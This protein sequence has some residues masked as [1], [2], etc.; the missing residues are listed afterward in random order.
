MVRPPR[1][2]SPVMVRMR[3]P[4]P[5][6]EDPVEAEALDW[7]VRLRDDDPPA[8]LEPQFRAWLDA[9]PAHRLA[10]V[11]A[12]QL[13]DS[14]DQ[15]APPSP[16]VRPVRPW[17][18]QGRAVAASIAATLVIGCAAVFVALDPAPDLQTATGEVRSVQLADGSTVILDAGSAIDVRI[19]PDDRTITLRKGRAWF[20]VA[21]EQ[22]RPF[23]VRSGSAAVHDIGTAFEVAHRG[24]G[25]SVAVSEGMVELMVDDGPALRLSE[26]QGARFTR[27][28]AR[29]AP[30]TTRIAA[31][32]SGRLEFQNAP[33]PEVLRDLER[34]GAPRAFLLDDRLKTVRLTGAFD[35]A[36]PEAAL[37][38]VLAR[39]NA[40]RRDFGPFVLLGEAGRGTAAVRTAAAK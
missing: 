30:H 26:G 22:T 39:A 13:F 36:T 19:T 11:E 38:A 12:E 37:S 14:L 15:I 7:L 6:A 24:A 5:T 17:A 27:G 10:F 40:S 8:D 4:D 33:L 35:A 34:Y 28:Q 2:V 23:V 25:G 1:H 3:S 16:M 18:G 9:E 32:R 21:H 20:N 31:W 29:R